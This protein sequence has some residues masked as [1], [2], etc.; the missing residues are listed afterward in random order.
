MVLNTTLWARLV[1][2]SLAGE[3]YYGRIDLGGGAKFVTTVARQLR[4]YQVQTIGRASGGM[5]DGS[6]I[7]SI[8]AG[9][10]LVA[11]DG[12]NGMW[13]LGRDTNVTYKLNS[14][15]NVSFRYRLYET[16][17]AAVAGGSS[18]LSTQME[19]LI[20]FS[21]ATT[22]AGAPSPSGPTGE[23]NVA[24]SSVKYVNGTS[25]NH[26]MKINVKNA[27]DSIPLGAGPQRSATT[28]L[29]LT[30][31]EVAASVTLT[32]TGDFTAVGAATEDGPAGK[33]WLDKDANCTPNIRAPV[34]TEGEAGFV[35]GEPDYTPWDGYP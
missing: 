7:L 5:G 18:P 4:H 3:T 1:L 29:D 12:P 9:G 2:L 13:T 10:A 33:V 30:L 27:S 32:A 20:R 14:K 35:A 34:G 6:V 25:T 16:P 23:I 21:N 19:D 28:G 24:T 11:V 15:S 26:V 8:Q 31:E 17:S 22:M